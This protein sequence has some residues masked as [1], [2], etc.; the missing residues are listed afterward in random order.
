MLAQEDI[1]RRV[2]VITPSGR[3]GVITR[4]LKSGKVTVKYTGSEL[5]DLDPSLLTKTAWDA[6][7]D[8]GI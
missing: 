7:S 3:Y 6:P 8:K 4:L 5:V 2:S 1:K